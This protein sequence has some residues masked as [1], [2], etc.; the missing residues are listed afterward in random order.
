MRIC[1]IGPKKSKES[2]KIK[3]I[4]EERGHTCRRLFMQD[5]YFEV[6]D[7]VFAAKHR[8]VELL[9]FDVFLFRAIDSTLHEALILA[10]YLQKQGKVVI[11]DCLA[12]L[13]YFPLM[14]FTRLATQSIPVLNTAKTTGLKSARD[15]LMEI[16]HPILIKSEDAAQKKITISEDWTESY[17]IV[18]TSKSKN[19]LFQQLVDVDHFFKVYVIGKK[20]VGGMKRVIQGDE[21]LLQYSPNIKSENVELNAKLTELALN[22]CSTLKVE[23]ASVDIIVHSGKHFVLAVHRA[24][25]FLRF[26]KLTGIQFGE[27][28]VKYAEKKLQRYNEN[29]LK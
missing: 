23:I 26:Q 1:V 22:A 13:R 2:I 27:E 3:E 17:D 19:F 11:D 15:V 10:E 25:K 9:S 12:S 4:A 8:K 21:R 20:A 14:T 6:D 29:F 28:I 7:S 16:D 24:P 5:I 18:R